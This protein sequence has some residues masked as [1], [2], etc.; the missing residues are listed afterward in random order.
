MSVGD[1]V[2]SVLVSVVSVG[3]RVLSVPVRVFV[4]VG[5]RVLPVP[6]RECLCLLVIGC[7][8]SQ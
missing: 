2:L 8:L 6:V 7:C 3:D 1:R 5:D 4:S